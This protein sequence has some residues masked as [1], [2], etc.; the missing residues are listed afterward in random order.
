MI[1]SDSC[2][3]AA[4]AGGTSLKAA[5]IQNGQIVDGSFFSLPIRSDGSKEEILQAYTALGAAAKTLAGKLHLAITE[6]AVCIPGPFDYAN[7]CSL[8]QHKYQSVFQIPLRPWIQEGIGHPIPITFLHDSSAFLLGACQ[9]LPDCHRRIC[10]VTIGTGLGF[11]CILD[12]ILQENENGGPGISIFKRSYL[13]QTAED[14]VSKRGILQ[15]YYHLAPS[16]HEL[17]VKELAD[18]ARQDNAN[19]RQ[20]FTDTGV[21]LGKILEPVIKAYSFDALILGGAIS[22]SADLFLA[23]LKA[24]LADCDV[25]V[26]PA[27]DIDLSPILGAALYSQNNVPIYDSHS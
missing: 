10:G 20:V 27:K 7:G 2:I 11:A 9:E 26:Y 3:F 12:G 23:S 22:K 4:D 19:A 14:F 21:H 17:T 8:M 25:A 15:Q 1:H 13:G 16:V 18:S 24:T 5:L 6:A